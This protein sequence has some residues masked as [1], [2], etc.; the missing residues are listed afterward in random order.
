MALLRSM[1]TS[2]PPRW[3]VLPELCRAEIWGAEMEVERLGLRLLRNKES[4][5]IFPTLLPRIG[6]NLWTLSRSSKVDLDSANGPLLPHP[7]ECC[8][9]WPGTVWTTSAQPTFL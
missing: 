8:R 4:G 5:K 9:A 3:Q 2:W 6:R 1:C 7:T